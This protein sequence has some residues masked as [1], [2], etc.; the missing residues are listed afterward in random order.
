MSEVPLYMPP[1]GRSLEVRSC[2]APPCVGRTALEATQG[3]MDGF[4]RQR[5]HKY[6]PEEEA[7]VGDRLKICSQLDSKVA[8]DRDGLQR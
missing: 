7:S 2:T 3:Q 8:C 5:P 1:S 4:F 6:H